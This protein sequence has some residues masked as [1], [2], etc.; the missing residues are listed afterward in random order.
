MSAEQSTHSQILDGYIEFVLEEERF[1]KSIFKF[2]KH[3]K[4]SERDFYNH[5]TSLEAIHLAFWETLVLNSNKVLEADESYESY[6]HKSKLLSFYFTLFE[7]FTLYRSYIKFRFDHDKTAFI[8]EGKLMRKA[9]QPTLK[10]YA[11]SFETIVNHISEDLGKKLTHEALW[12]QF[13]GIFKFWLEDSSKGFESTDVFVEK[14]VTVAHDLSTNLPIE[15]MLDYGKFLFK[16]M[17]A[18]L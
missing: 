14:S 16:E 9:I 17:K 13:L 5:F 8:S 6:D 11:S 18:H 4:V 10:S 12:L 3:L 7:N 15:S 1:P 2:C